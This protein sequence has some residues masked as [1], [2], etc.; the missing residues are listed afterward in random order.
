MKT[1]AWLA[2][3]F[4]SLGLISVAMESGHELLAA[5][6]FFIAVGVLYPPFAAMKKRWFIAGYT[7]TF[8]PTP[9]QI[10]NAEKVEKWV[11]RAETV[12]KV[13]SLFE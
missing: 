13:T 1:L 9:T 3:F 7:G 5:L 4:F 10:E 11:E 8:R 12:H 6:V 2:G